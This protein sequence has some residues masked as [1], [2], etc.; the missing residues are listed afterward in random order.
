MKTL[1]ELLT[2]VTDAEAAQAILT[3]LAA[4]NPPLPTTSWQSGSV[5]S[6]LVAVFADSEGNL[7]TGRI[8]VASGGYLS[9]ASGDW[10]TLLAYENYGITRD[11]AVA[12]QGLVQFTDGGGGPYT[13][14]AGVTTVSNGTR[15]YVVDVTG[16]LPV[17]GKLFAR[18]VATLV[19]QA[20]NV[21]N[22]AI[23]TLVTALSGVT[24]SNVVPWITV[25]GDGVT[26]TRGYVTLTSTAGGVVG[27]G[28][29]TV[30]AGAGPLFTNVEAVTLAAGV[31]TE[32]LFEAGAALVST[33][34]GN[35][36]I[37]TV[38][39]DPLGDITCNNPAPA[40]N[41]TWV[42][43]AGSDEQ[44]DASLRTECQNLLVAR[45][46]DWIAQ[47]IEYLVAQAPISSGTAITRTTVV[48]NPGGV[49]GKIGVY[50]ASAAGPVTLG[51]VADVQA[52]LEESRSLTSTVET[53]SAT[54]LAITITGTAK[55]PAAYLAEAQ[56]NAA[57]NLA[58]LASGTPIGGDPNAA[59]KIQLED[60]ISAIKAASY[61]SSGNNTNPASPTQLAIVAPAADVTVATGEV[62]VFT[63]NISWGSP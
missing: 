63:V 43:R 7:Y 34:V 37:T 11:E 36:T 56:A 2:P 42:V 26:P 6:V 12:T 50:I 46:V 35:G 19:G 31:P 53:I 18:V 30:Q 17:N 21:A 5:P 55:V 20:G 58:A 47:G 14:T 13:L 62:P 27:V 3:E 8:N 10:L 33:N 22:G 25:Y 40:A 24:V 48:T 16:T 59:Y 32:V 52:Y 15:T 39:V 51:D 41:T 54:A 4:Q 9:L 28:T 1:A 44:T 61:D 29:C 49:A 38:T 57:A 45:G 23:T 60:I